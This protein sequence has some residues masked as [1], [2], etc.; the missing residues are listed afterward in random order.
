M[1]ESLF[2]ELKAL[3]GQAL[4]KRLEEI[5][6]IPFQDWEAVAERLEAME[7]ERND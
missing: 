7:D 1:N 4:R 2:N 6:V 3:E 5:T